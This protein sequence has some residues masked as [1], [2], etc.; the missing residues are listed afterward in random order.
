MDDRNFEQATDTVGKATP[1]PTK[2]VDTLNIGGFEIAL[3]KL[4]AGELLTRR[5]W[6]DGTFVFIQVPSMV[7]S[8]IVPK[9]TS[10]PEA[11]KLLFKDREQ[12][13]IRYSFQVVMVDKDN[14]LKAWSPSI[15][16]IL[17]NDWT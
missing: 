7:N 1:M 2:P 11:A 8:E 4:K 12:S 3:S 5:A 16:D 13:S 6:P 15:E 17:S 10:L 9:M 14:N